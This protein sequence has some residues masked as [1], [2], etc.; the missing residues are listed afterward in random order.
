[1]K[2]LIYVYFWSK[3]TYKL[4]ND[5]VRLYEIEKNLYTA[6]ICDYS[7]RYTRVRIVVVFDW[8]AFESVKEKNLTGAHI[9]IIYIIFINFTSRPQISIE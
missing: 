5:T 3:F 2:A 9:E 8:Y 7:N 1:M 4:Q 6:I